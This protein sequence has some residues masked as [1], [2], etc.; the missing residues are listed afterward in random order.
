[1]CHTFC[2]EVI[3][4][5]LSSNAVPDEV[6]ALSLVLYEL[7]EGVVLLVVDAPRT[8]EFLAHPTLEVGQAAFF[9]GRLR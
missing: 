7:A 5:V 8:S 3:G 9:Q 2:R 1:M 4:N 6:S